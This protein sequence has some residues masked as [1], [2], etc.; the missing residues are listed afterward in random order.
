MIALADEEVLRADELE[1]FSAAQAARQTLDEATTRWKLAKASLAQRLKLRAPT[2]AEL[3]YSHDRCAC[4]SPMAYWSAAEPEGWDCAAVL[5]GRS[6]PRGVI[7]HRERVS[8]H[9]NLRVN[10]NRKS[11]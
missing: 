8:F 3:T 4:G 6:D 9:Q 1:A 10:H 11:L 7:A 5:L 2:E